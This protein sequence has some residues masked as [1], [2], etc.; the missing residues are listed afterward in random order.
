MRSIVDVYNLIWS[1]D[2]RGEEAKHNWCGREREFVEEDGRDEFI[3]GMSELA[4]REQSYDGSFLSRLGL[5]QSESRDWFFFLVAGFARLDEI[6]LRMIGQ[7]SQAMN[8]VHGWA[9]PLLLHLPHIYSAA[10]WVLEELAS[11][12]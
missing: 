1:T 12:A 6:V 7:S 4:R 2:E 9:G 11:K 8:R 3:R 10:R 5:V